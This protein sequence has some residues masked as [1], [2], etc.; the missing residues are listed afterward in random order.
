MS[1]HSG[2]VEDVTLEGMA[3][4]V[5]SLDQLHAKLAELR[6]IQQAQLESLEKV[7]VRG[8]YESKAKLDME[9]DSVNLYEQ[10]MDELINGDEVEAADPVAWSEPIVI[11]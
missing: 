10:L 7:G 3:T 9:G 8:D 4:E 11:D 5:K 1:A 6:T 2:E